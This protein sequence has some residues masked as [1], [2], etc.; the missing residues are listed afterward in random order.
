MPDILR[1][2]FAPDAGRRD[3]TRRLGFAQALASRRAFSFARQA[4][5]LGRSARRFPTWADTSRHLDGNRS[6]I[7]V[8]AARV[9]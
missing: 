8:D 3:R 1:S 5:L 9:N 7:E 6:V 2:P 4:L